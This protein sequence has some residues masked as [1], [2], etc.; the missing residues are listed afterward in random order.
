M[1]FVLIIIPLMLF[2]GIAA[3]CVSH[4]MCMDS[5]P[6]CYSGEQ[7]NFCAPCSS[8]EYLCHSIDDTCGSRCS[9]STYPTEGDCDVE[10]PLDVDA[11]WMWSGDIS[12]G[13]SQSGN[14]DCP[15][16]E[17]C[18][19]KAQYYNDQVQ[20]VRFTSCGS[21]FDT[22]FFLTDVFGET[23]QWRAS[24]YC[25]GDDCTDP[26]AYCSSGT[27]ETFTMEDLP[28][29][30]YWV[31]LAPYDYS[32]GGD[33]MM[34]VN[35][36]GAVE[37]VLGCVWIENDYNSAGE[38]QA[39]YASSTQE[40]FDLVR[41]RCPWANIVNIDENL[42]NGG[43]GQCWCQQGFTQIAEPG[44][45]WFNCWINGQVIMPA[46][47]PTPPPVE[48]WAQLIYGYNMFKTEM[49]GNP[50]LDESYM[51]DN[52]GSFNDEQQECAYSSLEFTDSYSSFSDFVREDSLSVAADFSAVASDTLGS[53][54]PTRTSVRSK[55]ADSQYY[56]YEMKMT[57]IRARMSIGNANT[58]KWNS[59]FLDSF[60]TMPSV[61]DSSQLHKFYV[62][63]WETYG[64]HLLKSAE[65]GGSI[66]GT[67]VANKCS[68]GSAYENEMA[69]QACLNSEYAQVPVEGC[70]GTSST[71]TGGSTAESALESKS[72]VV[73]GGDS[74]FNQIVQN[75]DD[76]SAD[77]DAWI[78]SLD[79]KPYIIGGNVDELWHIVEEA[80]RLG[81][82]YLNDG[83]NQLTDDEWTAIAQAMESAYADYQ[84][85]LDVKYNS[86]TGGECSIECNDV[87][88]V[89][90]HDCTCSGCGS[91]SECCSMVGLVASAPSVSYSVALVVCVLAILM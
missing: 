57:C 51:E 47:Q 22:V 35:S 59:D 36:G 90:E 25:H 16:D 37:D 33:W 70:A 63:F 45:G 48:P 2:Q 27:S 77:F 20:D 3:F 11:L 19:V 66:K 85:E 24:N 32:E 18:G 46:N 76:K 54:S 42:L 8:C 39:G 84:T 38:Q 52:R 30:Y 83:K 21:T 10:I 44:A 74:S 50:V 53:L 5:A 41:D 87:G 65:L 29:G 12:L 55:A 86:F 60:S 71:S 61:Y 58:L 26:D 17:M 28:V 43:S 62:E 72:I 75:F 56:I 4:D 69:F 40:C 23:I 89:N 73:K 31:I 78:N 79:S 13:Q 88:I 82:H 68:V 14:I 81:D 64:T 91:V 67:V 9:S 34:T 1:D 6:F 49:S 80:I 7:G 15:N